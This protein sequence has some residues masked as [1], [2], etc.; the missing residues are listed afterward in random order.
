MTVQAVFL[1]WLEGDKRG[2]GT[3][4]IPVSVPG[5]RKLYSGEAAALFIISKDQKVILKISGRGL[6]ESS[7]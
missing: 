1:L 7:E 4:A 3:V 6:G 2:D 5:K